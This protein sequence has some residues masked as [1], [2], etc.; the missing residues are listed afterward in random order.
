MGN[1]RV[2][3]LEPALVHKLVVELQHTEVAE[4]HIEL[5]LVEVVEPQF[6]AGYMGLLQIVDPHLTLLEML[7]C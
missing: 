3:I 7:K 6:V 1:I 4:P 2:D 5:L